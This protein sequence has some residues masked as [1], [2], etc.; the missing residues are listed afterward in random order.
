M[1][2][3]QNVIYSVCKAEITPDFSVK[4]SFRSCS[5][6]LI[7]YSRNICIIICISNVENRCVRFFG[8]P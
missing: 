7:C 6:M 1:V 3:F 2:K 4:W 8:I 5:N